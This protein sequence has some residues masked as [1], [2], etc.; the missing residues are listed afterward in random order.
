MLPL[1]K[2]G[3]AMVHFLI[4]PIDP[5]YPTI[6]IF[7]DDPSPI[8]H[9]IE[10]MN[11]GV[12]DVV[13]NGDYVFTLRLDGSGMWTIYKQ[14]SGVRSTTRSSAY[15]RQSRNPASGPSCRENLRNTG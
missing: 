10:R 12:A 11:C 9:V 2:R 15:V 7:A 5:A 3:T 6:D 4:I 8:L 1:F 13:R 14:D